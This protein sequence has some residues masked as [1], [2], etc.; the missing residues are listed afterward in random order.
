MINTQEKV[1]N[2]LED[3]N[4]YLLA[5]VLFDTIVITILEVLGMCLL[6]YAFK[7]QTVGFKGALVVGTVFCVVLIKLLLDDICKTIDNKFGELKRYMY[8]AIHEGT[9][10]ETTLDEI[11][12]EEEN[13]IPKVDD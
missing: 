2:K 4:D 12:K 10:K 11:L 13:H 8:V 3:V 7:V 9:R 1:K 6:V 5:N